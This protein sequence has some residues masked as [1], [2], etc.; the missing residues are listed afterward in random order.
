MPS[1]TSLKV[2]PSSLLS[3]MSRVTTATVSEPLSG[4]RSS[5]R[6]VLCSRSSVTVTTGC[7][8]PKLRVS[9][10]SLRCGTAANSVSLPPLCDALLKCSP[11]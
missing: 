8:R 6:S 9:D 7:V 3:L 1:V 10:N 5:C 4:A 11:T 2:L